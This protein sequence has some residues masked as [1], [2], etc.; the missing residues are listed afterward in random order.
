MIEIERPALSVVIP[1]FN[2]APRLGPTLRTA[3]AYLDAR[4]LRAEI[5]VVDDGSRDETCAIARGHALAD[6]RV[7]WVSL[8]RNR[9]KGAA[10]RT[11]VNAS[12]GERILYMDADSS[13]PIAELDRLWAVADRG[14]DVV[15]GSRGRLSG[16][17]RR[18][19]GPLR[20]ALGRAFGAL[21][22]GLVLEGV[23]D[24][25]CGFKLF[26]RAAALKVFAHAALDRFS[27]DV[28]VLALARALGLRVE[29]VPVAWRHD[30]RSRVS[31]LVEAPLM[32]YDVLR[33]RARYGRRPGPAHAR[34]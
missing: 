33:L 32:L 21:V 8:G 27:F 3:L 16:P 7:R 25:Q 18:S 20:A 22:R 30:P 29:E 6:R 12:L 19:Q 11:G 4:R 9:G 14:A 31:P 15:F 10:V 17:A 5:I 34:P 23:D 1:A 28:E 26:G 2:E 24:S 13:T